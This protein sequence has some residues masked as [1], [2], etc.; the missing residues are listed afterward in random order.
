M[1]P[2]SIPVPF[3]RIATFMQ[4]SSLGSRT[5]SHQLERFGAGNFDREIALVVSR[6]RF[7]CQVAWWWRGGGASQA[8]L[9]TL[10]KDPWLIGLLCL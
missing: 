4:S 10:A 9:G 6:P 5:G 1:A 8:E 3:S 2:P 7:G